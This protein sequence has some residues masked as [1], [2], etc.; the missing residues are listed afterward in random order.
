MIIPQPSARPVTCLLILL[1]MVLLNGCASRNLAPVDDHILAQ[2]ITERNQQVAKLSNWKING[3]IAFIGANKRDSAAINW[4]VG[5]DVQNNTSQRLDLTSTFGINILHLASSN[6][7]HTLEVD[8]K[9]YQTDDLNAL[10]TS[11]TGLT[12]PT[13]AMSYWLKGIA[14][15][16]QDRL[17]YDAVTQLPSQLVSNFADRTWLLRYN[18]YQL[19]GLNRLPSNVTISQDDLTI[20]IKIHK[21]TL[22]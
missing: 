5:R 21:W 20:K 11:L 6:N 22:P 1:V 8:G 13:E 17:E 19:I 16:P 18:N 3:Q 7:R 4:Q 14:Y 9:Q 15:Q 2:D 12:L 10:I